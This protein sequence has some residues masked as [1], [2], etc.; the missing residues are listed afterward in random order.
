MTVFLLPKTNISI[1]EKINYSELSHEEDPIFISNSLSYYLSNIKERI[2]SREK[3]WDSYKKY[4]NPYE[5]IHSPTPIKRKSVSKYK[6]IS[7]SYF[8]MIEILN[9]FQ[10]KYENPIRSFHLAEGPGGFIEAL[11]MTRKCKEDQYIGMTLQDDINDSNV[12]AW[13]KSQSFLSRFPNVLLENGS[14]FTG[15]ILNLQNLKH[16][17]EYYSS[18]MD[19]ITADGGFDFSMDFNQ[20]EI[21]ISKLLFGQVAFALTMQ[22]HNGTFILKIFDCFMKHTIDILYI[23][24]SFYEKIH[25]V[26]PQT[27]RYANSE[28]YIVCKGFLYRSSDEYYHF[29]EK[30]F[31][32]MLKDKRDVPCRFLK[33]GVPYYFIQKIEEYNAIFGQKQIQNIHFTMS[34]IDNKYKQEKIEALIKKNVQ[35]SVEWCIKYG[36]PHNIAFNT[37]NLFTYNISIDPNSQISIFH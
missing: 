27:S 28:K 19:L 31:I 5:Y 16:C 37:I 34:L 9:L 11:A 32:D 35:K 26:K 22:K 20:Q 25:V 6:P 12:P 13:K 15:N 17:R 14:D 3:L 10:L 7:R 21:V 29:L 36:I 18:S 33:M 2:N 30:T 23:L 4:T 1:Y 8:K 24:S